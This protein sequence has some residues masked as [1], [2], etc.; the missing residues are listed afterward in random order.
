MTRPVC[1]G[2]G[3]KDYKGKIGGITADL[4]RVLIEKDR[5]LVRGSCLIHLM[6]YARGVER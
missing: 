4:Y 2:L 5:I 3:N 1:L 6:M